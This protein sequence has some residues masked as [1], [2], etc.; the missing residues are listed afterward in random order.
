MGHPVFEKK[1]YAFLLK[2][3]FGFINTG[4]P[5]KD[6]TSETIVRYLYFLFPFDQGR[7]LNITLNRHNLRVSS[8]LYSLIL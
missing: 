3:N 2:Q 5:T 1:I 8:R 6:D 7:K 4:L